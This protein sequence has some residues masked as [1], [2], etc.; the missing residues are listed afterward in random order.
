[1]F[2]G[3]LLIAVVILGGFLLAGVT[4]GVLIWYTVKHP[5]ERKEMIPFVAVWS[6]AIL[7]A[8]GLVVLLLLAMM[9]PWMH[10]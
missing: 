8:V 9:W 2:H 4:E 3:E 7:A 6:T 5:E 1:M 10:I